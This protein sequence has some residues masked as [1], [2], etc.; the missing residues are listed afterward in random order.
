MTS[1]DGF[2]TDKTKEDA[3][4]GLRKSLTKEELERI[5]EQR[6]FNDIK[7]DTYTY[8]IA[9]HLDALKQDLRTKQMQVYKRV[10]NVENIDNSIKNCKTQLETGNITETLPDSDT[11]M[12]KREL[13]TY[14]KHQEWLKLGEVRAI[15]KDLAG[16][17]ALVGHKDLIGNLIF[18]EG[19]FD[20]YF[21]KIENELQYLDHS[22]FD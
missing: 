7:P 6:A 19:E 13:E 11:L 2:R 9:L 14:I 1:H 8:K 4:E 22:M 20:R 17:R 3:I 10:W 15:P 12:T 16:V 21:E 5:K 18:T